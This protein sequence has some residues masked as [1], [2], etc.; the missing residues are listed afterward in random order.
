MRKAVHCL[1]SKVSREFLIDAAPGSG[2]KICALLIA[3]MLF[4]AALINRIIY[5]TP[6]KTVGKQWCSDARKILGRNTLRI[7]GADED[8]EEYG[9]DVC[10]TFQAINGCLEGLQAICRNDR[11]LVI[12]D[13]FHHASGVRSWGIETDGAFSDAKFVLALSGTAIRSDGEAAVWLPLN[14]HGGISLPDAAVYR[15]TYGQAVDLEYCRPAS[16][17][18]HRGDFTVDLEDGESITVSRVRTY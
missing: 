10:V 1:R 9:L 2:K 12:G 11:T 4:D 5:I 6:R 15:L 3:K 13:E 17:H 16:F 14:S 8:P 7:T 18:I